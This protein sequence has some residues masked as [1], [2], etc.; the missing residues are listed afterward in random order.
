MKGLV[1]IIGMILLTQTAQSQSRPAY[2]KMKNEHYRILKYRTSDCTFKNDFYRLNA[3][4]SAGASGYG[5]VWTGD[6]E[7]YPLVLRVEAS[8][9]FMENFGAGLI[10]NSSRCDIAIKE[11]GV[12]GKDIVNFLGPALYGRIGFNRFIF[13]A[14]AGVGMLNWSFS[15]YLYHNYDYGIYTS[16]IGG[17]ISAGGSYMLARNWGVALNIQSS[18]GSI[19]KMQYERNPTALG[20]TIGIHYIFLI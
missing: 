17:F 4:V 3:A 11:I 10:F 19:K 15:R 14:S 6:S 1:F 16:S 2:R 5:T 8:Y 18:A 12:I 7:G 9:F 20:F 13:T